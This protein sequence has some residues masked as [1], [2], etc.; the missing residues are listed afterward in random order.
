MEGSVLLVQWLVQQLVVLQYLSQSTKMGARQDDEQSIMH[1]LE[2]MVL[3]STDEID[4]ERHPD[5]EQD[6][7]IK[8]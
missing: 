3:Q 8:E 1:T 4:V 6:T 5:T 7:V 2:R